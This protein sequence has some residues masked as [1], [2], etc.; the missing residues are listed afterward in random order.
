MIPLFMREVAD[1]QEESEGV[2]SMIQKN[3]NG[4]TVETNE[5]DQFTKVF[6]L[7]YEPNNNEEDSDFTERLRTNGWL[8]RQLA[9]L[10]DGQ[11]L[12][13]DALNISCEKLIDTI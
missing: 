4:P 10:K 12:A 13:C 7:K 2:P 5:E 3:I 11:E 1:P 6:V 9:T 8:K